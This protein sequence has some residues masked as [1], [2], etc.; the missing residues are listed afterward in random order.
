MI[1]RV[2]QQNGL[3]LLPVETTV[4]RVLDQ[5]GDFLSI[6]LDVNNMITHT[7]KHTTMRSQFRCRLVID[8]F[9]FG[10]DIVTNNV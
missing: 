6:D 9:S 10:G 8:S 3:E 4:Q 5:T 7:H 2:R 1:G